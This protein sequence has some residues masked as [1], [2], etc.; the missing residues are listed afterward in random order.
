[1]AGIWVRGF[2]LLASQLMKS[3]GALVRELGSARAG[4]RG[5]RTGKFAGAHVLSWGRRIAERER[6]KQP[7]TLSPGEARAAPTSLVRLPRSPAEWL[8]QSM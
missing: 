7:S 2:R 1:M 5:R 4:E 6:E 3:A 8:R